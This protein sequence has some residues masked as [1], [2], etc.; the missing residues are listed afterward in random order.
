MPHWPMPSWHNL[1]Q[2]DE[3]G[4][5]WPNV[6]L[7]PQPL[8]AALPDDVRTFAAVTANGLDEGRAVV[9]RVREGAG[10]EMPLLH[11]AD[12]A[13][14][15]QGGRVTAN[16]LRARAL[17]PRER[18]S[19][20][21]RGTLA[22]VAITLV[23]GLL[24]LGAALAPA[25]SDAEQARKTEQR[26]ADVGAA[27][28]TLAAQPLVLRRLERTATGV[29]LALTTPARS[30]ATGA[31]AD[32]RLAELLEHGVSGT[33]ETWGLQQQ[34]ARDLRGWRDELQR[35][36]RPSSRALRTW[37]D[38]LAKAFAALAVLVGAIVLWSQSRLGSARS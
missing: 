1:G 4:R 32:E 35:E 6:L 31:V 25:H 38:T 3:D 8:L 5:G 14:M 19:L 2:F 20:V 37:L 9:L 28:S 16:N 23:S 26:V 27:L 7:V 22:V 15:A 10:T 24:A 17:R 18:L 34:A 11:E 29:Q 33:A 21:D 13:R 12:F 36:A 30:R